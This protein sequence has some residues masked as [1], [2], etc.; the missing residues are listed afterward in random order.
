[1]QLNKLFNRKSIP[2]MGA[3]I[4]AAATY[5]IALTDTVADGDLSAHEIATNTI[6]QAQDN[7]A[8]A[9]A[10]VSDKF[11]KAQ[12][13]STENLGGDTYENTYK[14]FTQLLNT[15]DFSGH[16]FIKKAYD[17]NILIVGHE[18]GSDLQYY[19]YGDKQGKYISLNSQGDIDV[20]GISIFTDNFMT[21]DSLT[22]VTVAVNLAEAESKGTFSIKSLTD[23]DSKINAID[24]AAPLRNAPC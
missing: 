7:I 18:G 22:G 20:H 13:D 14:V 3:V 5:N 17:N 11:C 16:D 9:L 19:N 24:K 2:A 23:T 6:E 10:R 1:M 21:N 4:I 8:A 15:P 12:T